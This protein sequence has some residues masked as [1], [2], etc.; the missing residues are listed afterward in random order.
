VAARDENT[1]HWMRVFYCGDPKVMHDTEECHR[2]QLRARDETIRKLTELVR[3]AYLLG[4]FAGHDN[5]GVRM[6][7]LWTGSSARKALDAINAEQGGKDN[8]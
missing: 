6:M 7:D 5:P 2:R 3:E 4:G 1:D 8:T